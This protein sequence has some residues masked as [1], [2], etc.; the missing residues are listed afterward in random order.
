VVGNEGFAARLPNYVNREVCIHSWVGSSL[1]AVVRTVV[2]VSFRPYYRLK[3]V[4]GNWHVFTF[5][6]KGT[7]SLGS[8]EVISLVITKLI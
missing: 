7:V 5:C 8:G 6:T 1:R 4:V 2:R 3:L